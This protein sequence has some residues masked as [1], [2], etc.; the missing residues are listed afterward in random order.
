MITWIVLLAQ[1]GRQECLPYRVDYLKW[2]VSGRDGGAEG[3][4][5]WQLPVNI[6]YKETIN[7]RRID[8]SALIKGCYRDITNG[9]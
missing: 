2:W 7:I 9:E 8:V 4:S 6:N 1:D 3:K 5:V